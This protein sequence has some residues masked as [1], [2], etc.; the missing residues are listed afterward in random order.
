MSLMDEKDDASLERGAA[1]DIVRLR[2]RLKIRENIIGRLVAENERLR[3]GAATSC[4]TV[5]LTDEERA[6]IEWA[7]LGFGNRAEELG[8]RDVLWMRLAEAESTLRK[9]LARLS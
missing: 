8:R 5:T 7:A 4:E 1:S 6:A 3:N 9:L 2:W